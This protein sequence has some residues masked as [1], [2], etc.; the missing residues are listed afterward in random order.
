L[1][2]P[3]PA[4]AT[5]AYDERAITVTWQPIEA[6]PAT[7]TAAAGEVLPSRIIGMTRPPIMY[8][9]YDASDPDSPIK[10]T[11]APIAGPTYSDSRLVWGAKRCYTVRAAERVAGAIIESDA[12]PAR[13]ETLVDTFAPAAPKGVTAISSDGA[14][15]LIWEPNAENDLAGYIV[16]RGS[17]AAGTLDPITPEPI[18]ETRFTDGVKPGVSYVYAIKAVDK[19]G[20][21]SPP[22][23]RVTETA[24]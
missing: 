2:P 14:I 1:P 22:S 11:A 16:L 7:E 24:R 21:A 12:A 3:P 4:P 23:S 8:N 19:A 20:N 17:A 13:C 6:A 9:V 5:I 15:N 10:L 18:Q